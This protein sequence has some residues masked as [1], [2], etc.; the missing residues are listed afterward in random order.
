MRRTTILLLLLLVILP[1]RVIAENHH[2]A[3][4]VMRKAIVCA[5]LHLRGIEHYE[6]NSYIRGSVVFSNI[7]TLLQHNL[8]SRCPETN[9]AY[10]L[11][12][13]SFMEYNAPN[14]YKQTI[15]SEQNSIPQELLG[16]DFTLKYFNFNLYNT[17]SDDVII[18]PLS[19]NAHAY[20]KFEFVDSLTTEGVYGIRVIPRVRSKQLFEGVICIDEG[21][22]QLSYVN[23]KIETAIGDINVEQQFVNVADNV[24]LMKLQVYNVDISLFGV[25]G[26]AEYVEQHTYTLVKHSDTHEKVVMSQRLLSVL[27]KEHLSRRDMVRGVRY[28]KRLISKLDTISNGL[29]ITTKNK[30]FIVDSGKVNITNHDW[31]S[32]RPMGLSDLESES[33]NSELQRQSNTRYV[34]VDQPTPLTRL[35]SPTW[36]IGK[37]FDLSLSGLNSSIAFYHPVTGFALEQKLT[38]GYE[39]NR[40]RLQLEGTG[41]Y[42]FS[43]KDFWYELKAGATLGS[44]HLTVKRGN[45]YV[46]WKGTKGDTWL[47][48]S[49]ISLF[50]K[51]N[52]KTLARDKYWHFDYT[53][54]P[55]WGLELDVNFHVDEYS[56]VENHCNF[57]IFRPKRRFKPNEVVNRYVSEQ[58]LAPY[59]QATA[60]LGI[61]YTPRLKYYTTTEGTRKIVGSAF[62]TI[63]FSITQ[64]V[65]AIAGNTDFVHLNW[66]LTRKKTFSMTDCF[67]W[68]AEAGVI[69]N[70]KNNGF[71]TWQHFEGSDKVFGLARVASGYNGF[72]TFKPYEMSTNDWYVKLSAHYQTQSLLIKKIPIFRNWLYTE[73]IHVKAAVISN[74]DVYTELGYGLGQILLVLRTTAFVSFHNKEFESVCFRMAFSLGDLLKNAR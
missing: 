29:E 42:A 41:G 74:D 60:Q 35:V 5:P 56:S 62:P 38:L 68:D 28:S 30:Y 12:T 72:V 11:E 59:K 13:F 52:F 23:L 15:I 22:W 17:S 2:D 67:N 34:L 9:Y 50:T 51:R 31:E 54:S 46:D 64:G 20:Y 39:R 57:S 43:D 32:L 33:L 47:N 70:N 26:R 19:R 63:G 44:H 48:N 25:K 69:L 71:A 24:N 66:S 3:E 16:K 45:G 37:R 10:M 1:C 14:T 21:S 53:S 58:D 36:K 40:L 73:E 65:S 18:S 55:V 27:E 4:C 7:P 6:A 61:R 49:L 8:G